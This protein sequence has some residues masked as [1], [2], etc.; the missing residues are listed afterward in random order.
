MPIEG[1]SPR[2]I[3]TYFLGYIT[4]YL[5][6]NKPEVKNIQSKYFGSVMTFHRGRYYHAAGENG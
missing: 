2:C 6:Q 4:Y 3:T 5:S 1:A